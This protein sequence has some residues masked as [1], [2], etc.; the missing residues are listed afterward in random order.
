MAD[1][2]AILCWQ[3]LCQKF[4]VDVTAKDSSGWL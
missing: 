4:M 3:M 1:I 2:V